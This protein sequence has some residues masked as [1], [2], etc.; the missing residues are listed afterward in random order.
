MDDGEKPVESPWALAA[1][2]AQ[3]R[4]VRHRAAQTALL[5]TALALLFP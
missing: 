2:L 1:L 3:A 4:R 5:L